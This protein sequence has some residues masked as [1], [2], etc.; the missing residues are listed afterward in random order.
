MILRKV[1]FIFLLTLT[2]LLAVGATA[3]KSTPSSCLS[4]QWLNGSKCVGCPTNAT[5]N[6]KTFKC[7]KNFTASG[8][9]CVQTTCTKGQWMKEGKCTAC[10][11][12]ATCNDGKV[13]K[14]NNGFS[15]KSNTC[16]VNTTE[17]C[18]VYCAGTFTRGTKTFNSCLD[19][20]KGS[21]SSK[22]NTSASSNQGAMSQ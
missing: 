7:N 8:S 9:K 19:S 5:C 15:Q 11:A 16:V 4:T 20:C 22:G 12:N 21:S 14:C 10:P 17:N 18:S 6:G 2:T 3:K 1:V 13:F